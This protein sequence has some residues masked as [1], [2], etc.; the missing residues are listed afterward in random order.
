M[1]RVLVFNNYSLENVLK[2]VKKS[3]NL[4]IIYTE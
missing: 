4:I 2:E 1:T 3:T